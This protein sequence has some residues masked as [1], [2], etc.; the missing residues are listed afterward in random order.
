MKVHRLISDRYDTAD[1]IN[2]FTK[3][4]TDNLLIQAIGSPHSGSRSTLFFMIC[5]TPP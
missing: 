2:C 3:L 1:M 5:I 4:I